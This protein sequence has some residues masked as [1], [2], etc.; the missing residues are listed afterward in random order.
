[1]SAKTQQPLLKPAQRA[2]QKAL[3]EMVQFVCVTDGGW[4]DT[5]MLFSSHFR[6]WNVAEYARE[7]GFDVVELYLADA[8]RAN[9]DQAM[10]STAPAVALCGGGHGDPTR[11]TGTGLDVLLE[12]ANFQ[13]MNNR[14]GEFMSCSFGQSWNKRR[15]A[16][17]LAEISYVDTVWFTANQPN[18]PIHDDSAYKHFECFHA[19]WRALIEDKTFR[20]A[21]IDQI[22][23]FE[24]WL[25][26]MTPMEKFY[27][28]INFGILQQVERNDNPTSPVWNWKMRQG[29][30]TPK[31]VLSDNGVQLLSW[32]YVQGSQQTYTGQITLNAIGEH[33]LKATRP[34]GKF[35]EITIKIKQG[36]TPPDVIFETPKDGD[37]FIQGQT[38]NISFKA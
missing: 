1:M 36:T 30:T 34:D 23:K 20:E 17:A 7:K 12:P 25:S 13:V 8:I 31:I 3:D 18:D 11:F 10:R 26:R 33:K 9:F 4:N 14:V 2:I 19:P 22:A 28:Q 37:E 29:T 15:E 5:A 38:I 32:D 27:G 21:C 16:G 6:H 24:Y 35:A